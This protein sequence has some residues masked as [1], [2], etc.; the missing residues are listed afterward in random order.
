MPELSLY[1]H[2]AR[3]KALV[4]AAIA[5]VDRQPYY[6]Q[7]QRPTEVEALLDADPDLQ[8]SIVI[9]LMALA[10]TDV[11]P[12]KRL[13]GVFGGDEIQSPVRLVSELGSQRP[14][15]TRGDVVLLL[16]LAAHALRRATRSRG[17]ARHGARLGPDRRGREGGAARRRRRARGAHPRSRQGARRVPR[18]REEPAGEGSRPP[19][20][21]A[22]AGGLGRLGR[23]RRSLAVRHRRHVGHRVARPSRV[24][25]RTGRGDDRPVLGRER[26]GAVEGLAH[27]G[28]G[29]RRCRR[30]RTGPRRDARRRPCLP[31]D[32][33]RAGLRVGR[34]AL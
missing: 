26:R 5:V 6:Y 3:A 2:R 12:A 27:A 29:A 1:E 25:H 9:S 11:P 18:R 16:A 8:R 24:A 34:E 31:F 32:R 20:R 30:R 13:R 15:F 17:V 4:D 23:R 33:S 22:P 10:S 21:A 19:P 14:P 28:E 7:H